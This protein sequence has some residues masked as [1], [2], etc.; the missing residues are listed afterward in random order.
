MQ[1]K[2]EVVAWLPSC[3]IGMQLRT[4]CVE[5]MFCEIFIGSNNNRLVL[6]SLG[7]GLMATPMQRWGPIWLHPLRGCGLTAILSVPTAADLMTAAAT[8]RPVYCWAMRVPALQLAL[9]CTRKLLLESGRVCCC[10]E[11]SVPRSA[12]RPG[13]REQL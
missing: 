2:S 3:T 10:F 11:G 1:D 5:R 9:Q 7:C 12:P 4:L 8:G 13:G 6:A